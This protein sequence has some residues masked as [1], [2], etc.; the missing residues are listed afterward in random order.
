MVRFFARCTSSNLAAFLR[1]SRKEDRS[2]SRPGTRNYPRTRCDA[3]EAQTQVKRM[4]HMSHVTYLCFRDLLDLSLALKY[5]VY[6]AFC[7]ADRRGI[8]RPQWCP[9]LQRTSAPFVIWGTARDCGNAGAA[10]LMHA[11]IAPVSVQR[12][13]LFELRG[14]V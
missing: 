10:A 9:R 3:E 4:C 7:R 6:L 12:W 2:R 14:F 11:V 13:S 5:F 8:S 1:V